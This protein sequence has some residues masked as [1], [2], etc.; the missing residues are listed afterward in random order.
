MHL[1]DAR[2]LPHF[3]FLPPACQ[4]V[5]VI[6]SPPSFF[7]QLSPDPQHLPTVWCVRAQ[8][9]AFFEFCPCHHVHVLTHISA[10]VCLPAAEQHQ[11]TL[12]A[13]KD[14][15]PHSDR[16]SKSSYRLRHLVS[17]WVWNGYI[18]S[19][20]SLQCFLMDPA[21]CERATENENV[22]FFLK[23]K[24]KSCSSKPVILLTTPLPVSSLHTDKT[25][26]RGGKL[27]RSSRC[28]GGVNPCAT[29]PPLFAPRAST[30][31]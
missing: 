4:N 29:T 28:R 1:T 21:R 3:N 13:G 19:P 6:C 14:S 27:S 2:R 23:K 16:L 31:V 10:E 15:G 12:L 22:F 18:S 17:I 9:L 25:F 24:K 7:S 26:A 11:V 30:G 5:N 20:D 8:S